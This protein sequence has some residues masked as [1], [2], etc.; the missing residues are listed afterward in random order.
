MGEGCWWLAMSAELGGRRPGA[1][2][3]TMRY[4]AARRGSNAP[5]RSAWGGCVAM[6]ASQ[7]MWTSRGSVVG[8]GGA[9]RG[10]F[11][12]SSRVGESRTAQAGAE[13]DR[14]VRSGQAN[15]TQ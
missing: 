5:A 7:Y 10:G 4:V 6:R 3:G 14:S 11:V 15:P 9:Y 12:P 1:A 8:R 13:N 2:A